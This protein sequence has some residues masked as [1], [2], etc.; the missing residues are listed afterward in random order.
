MDYIIRTPTFADYDRIMELLIEMANYN[1]LK[2]LQNPA[3]NDKYIRNV[4]TQCLRAGVIYVGEVE[5][6]IEGVIIGA[7][8]PNVWL[9][10]VVWL[11]EIAFWVSEKYRYTALGVRL[12]KNYKDKALEMKEQGIIDNFVIT[13]LEKLPVDYA[14]HGFK[15]VETNWAWSK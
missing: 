3:Y 11:R 14:K 6:Q 1:E 12:L 4:L 13:S 15:R 7:Q 5:E 8:M 10:Q 9:N 2:E